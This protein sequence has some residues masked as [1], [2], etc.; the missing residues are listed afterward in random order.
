[1]QLTGA[2]LIIEGP[3]YAIRP[4]F[5]K[6]RKLLFY[7]LMLESK[8]LSRILE[9]SIFKIIIKLIWKQAESGW[10]TEINSSWIKGAKSLGITKSIILLYSST[11]Q[12]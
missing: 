4:T 6:S 10:M 7:H 1:M 8:A 2:S 3:E 9:L 11:S 12:Y 5:S